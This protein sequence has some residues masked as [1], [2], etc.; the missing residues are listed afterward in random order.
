M[1]IQ[2][3]ENHLTSESEVEYMDNSMYLVPLYDSDYNSS[4]S[5]H[6][7]YAQSD[8]SRMS[9][10]GVIQELNDD[11]KSIQAEFSVNTPIWESAEKFKQPEGLSSE[12]IEHHRRQFN[13]SIKENLQMNEIQGQLNG[14][15]LSQI[16]LD[17][18]NEYR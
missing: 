1:S 2:K 6:E 17:N 3:N 13:L 16:L 18:Q 8:I 5:D 15:E 9:L 14:Q 11:C 12:E 10:D 7:E 4:M